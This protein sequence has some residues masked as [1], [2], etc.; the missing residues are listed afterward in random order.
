[1]EDELRTLPNEIE[2]DDDSMVNRYVNKT[3]KKKSSPSLLLIIGIVIG[4]LVILVAIVIGICC[5][6]CQQSSKDIRRIN[7]DTSNQSNIS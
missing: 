5:C 2:L 6:C 3:P 1:M 4:G 7:S